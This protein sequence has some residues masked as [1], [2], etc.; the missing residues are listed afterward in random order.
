MNRYVW[1]NYGVYI[2]NLYTMGLYLLFE[3][4][5]S[6]LLLNLASISPRRNAGVWIFV[7]KFLNLLNSTESRFKSH[8]K[9]KPTISTQDFLFSILKFWL[10]D[11]KDHTFDMIYVTLVDR[12]ACIYRCISSCMFSLWICQQVQRWQSLDTQKL[13]FEQSHKV[14]VQFDVFSYGCFQK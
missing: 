9:H 12:H 7:V 3:R 10:K 14:P 8:Q 1:L 2:Y 13:N 5:H 6:P 4:G 11:F